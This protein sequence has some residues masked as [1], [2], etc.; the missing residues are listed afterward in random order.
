MKYTAE[1]NFDGLLRASLK[2]RMDIYA[3]A[4]QNGLKP[5]MNAGN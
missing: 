3:K 1:F 4:V 2:D 5:A